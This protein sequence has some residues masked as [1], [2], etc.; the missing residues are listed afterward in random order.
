MV[1][2]LTTTLIQQQTLFTATATSGS[3]I[4]LQAVVDVLQSHDDATIDAKLAYIRRDD[5]VG[6]PDQANPPI[7]DHHLDLIQQGNAQERALRRDQNMPSQR[8]DVQ[9]PYAPSANGKHSQVVTAGGILHVCGWRGDVPE[10]GQ[11]VE[12]V[13]AQTV[14]RHPVVSPRCVRTLPPYPPLPPT[15][16]PNLT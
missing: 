6:A 16:S 11:I 8:T 13:V 3:L 2:F 7:P 1:R 12:G 14:G 5:D 9:P 15:D 10:T 4:R